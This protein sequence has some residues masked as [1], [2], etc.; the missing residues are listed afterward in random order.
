MLGWCAKGDSARF[1]QRAV[2]NSV[3]SHAIRIE[4]RLKISE[5]FGTN[6]H[7]I[8]SFIDRERDTSIMKK[9]FILIM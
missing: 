9:H 6:M 8:I 1:P 3:F 5:E 7:E 2:A 4:I